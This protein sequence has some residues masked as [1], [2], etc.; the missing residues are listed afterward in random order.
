MISFF[1]IIKFVGSIAMITFVFFIVL[2][3]VNNTPTGFVSL[4]YSGN[5]EGSCENSCGGTTLT[6]GGDCFCD[7]RCYSKGDCCSDIRVYCS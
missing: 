2:S 3:T 5:S 7:D 4:S 6:A 1:D